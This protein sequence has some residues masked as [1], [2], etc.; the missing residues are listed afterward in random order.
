MVI[1][2]PEKNTMIVPS[3]IKSQAIRNMSS[4]ERII[5]QKRLEIIEQ[6]QPKKDFTKNSNPETDVI[7][8]FK[9]NLKKTTAIPMVIEIPEKNTMIVPSAIK[10]HAI[11][12]MSSGERIMAKKRLEIIE[13]KQPKK[14]FTKNSNPETDVIKNFKINLKKT[15]AIPMVIEIPEKNTMIVPSAIKSQAIRN[16]SS[17]ERI[18]AKK[19]LEIIEQKQPKKD[20]TKNSN[21]ET[22]V[23]KNPT[24]TPSVIKPRAIRNMPS[25][26]R[27]MAQKRLNIIEQ[28]MP[29]KDFIENSNHEI[30]K[31]NNLKISF[32]KMTGT[33]T[34]SL[35]NSAL[36]RI[37]VYLQFSITE[38]GYPKKSIIRQNIFKETVWVNNNLKIGFK[39]VPKCASSGIRK[40]FDFTELV[41]YKD[42]PTSYTI[43]TIIREPIKRFISAYIEICIYR[44]TGQY[45]GGRFRYDVKPEWC[46]YN[47]RDFL[48]KLQKNQ[49]ISEIEKFLI[50]LTKIE[51]EW[52]FFD[53]HIAPMIYHISDQNSILQ[54]NL[55]IF[56][57]EKIDEIENFLGN[58]INNYNLCINKNLQTE[59]YNYVCNNLEVKKRIE[60]LYSMDILL[61]NSIN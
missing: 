29:K 39:G 42:V 18:M 11:R 61:Y 13:Q 59:I 48:D 38:D 55:N 2:I 36:E 31:T 10:S 40:Q 44:E 60:T 58:K 9:I 22:Y 17:G 1:E 15:T 12:N 52:Y 54:K 41:N 45:T 53:G 3:A 16:M 25:G 8:N 23:I 51:K 49:N 32:K 4:G 24:I 14:D 26:E 33:P 46:G 19:R 27:I 5:A 28:K 20:F 56:K 50:F 47:I 35:I 57:L 34:R 6:K 37:E 7:K 43:F 21:H 30:N